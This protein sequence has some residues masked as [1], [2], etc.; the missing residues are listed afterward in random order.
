MFFGRTF[1]KTQREIRIVLPDKRIEDSI[2]INFEGI[3]DQVIVLDTEDLLEGEFEIP[4]SI[5]Y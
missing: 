2:I 3:R 4:K 1:F 5:L